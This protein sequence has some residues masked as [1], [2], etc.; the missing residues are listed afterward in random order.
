[1]QQRFAFNNPHFG[2]LHRNI[3]L[4]AQRGLPLARHNELAGAR[5][6]IVATGPTLT[7][8]RLRELRR[9]ALPPAQA[10]SPAPLG[11]FPAPL[12]PCAP[13]GRSPAPPWQLWGLKQALTVLMQAGIPPGATVAM[14]PD[15]GQ[16]TKYPRVV[17]VTY[18]LAS[19]CDP[20]LFDHLAGHDVRVFHSATGWHG[21]APDMVTGERRDLGELDLYRRAWG[22]GDCVVGG[23][24]VVN[25]ALGLAKYLGAGEVRLFGTPFGWREGTRY[26]ADGV[27]GAAGNAGTDLR[28]ELPGERPWLTRPDLL[29]SALHVAM[30]LRTGE[31]T[32]AGSSLAVDLAAQ[33]DALL[34]RLFPGQWPFTT[35]TLIHGQE[36]EAGRCLVG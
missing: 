11:Q 28:V 16:A 4:A 23:Y 6:A 24:T 17:G 8:P 5:I 19:S 30:V 34:H 14:D 18:W 26:Y 2:H 15:P 22:R 27:D 36:A 35:E 10:R 33:P 21:H 25:R 1:L 32:V 9:M 31:V 12:A 3:L 13:Q 29:A 20:A 7:P